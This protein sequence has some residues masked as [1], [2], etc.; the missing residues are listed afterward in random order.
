MIT[1]GRFFGSPD[2]GWLGKYSVGTDPAMRSHEAVMRVI[3]LP[4]MSVFPTHIESA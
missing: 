4:T 3:P 2:V 1:S